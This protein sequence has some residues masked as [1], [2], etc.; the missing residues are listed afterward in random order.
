MISRKSTETNVTLWFEALIFIFS[1][2]PLFAILFIKDL[3]N[4][5]N[6]LQFGASSWNLSVSYSSIT[7]LTI[8]SLSTLIVAPL[9]RSLTTHQNGGVAINIVKCNQVKGD[10]LNYTLPFLIGLFG[11]DYNS[12]QSIASLIVFLLFMFS[13]I[14]KEQICLLNPMFLLLNIRLYEIQYIEVG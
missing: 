14:H 9:I 2:Y 4:I 13:F 8:S 1:Y 3:D 6:R 11:F 12:L 10:M 5:P 7:L